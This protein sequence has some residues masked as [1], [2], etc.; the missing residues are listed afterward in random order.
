MT[1]VAITL[2]FEVLIFFKDNFMRRGNRC[3]VGNG[4]KVVKFDE[5]I[6]GFWIL[7]SR[8]LVLFVIL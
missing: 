3:D 6:Q 4:G 8:F 5:D 2:L 7:D 1:P